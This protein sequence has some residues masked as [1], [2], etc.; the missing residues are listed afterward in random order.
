M[1]CLSTFEREG[2]LVDTAGT[3][4]HRTLRKEAQKAIEHHSKATTPY[5]PP[6]Q[7]I[8]LGTPQLRAW[9]YAHPFALLYYLSSISSAFAAL[10]SETVSRVSSPLKMVIYSDEIK[11]DNPLRPDNGR[12]TQSIYWCFTDWPQWALQRAAVWLLLGV[13]RTTLVDEMPGGESGL[14]RFVLNV[15]F[16][17]TSPSFTLGILMPVGVTALLV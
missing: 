16:R 4:S 5:G 1:A 17:V 3:E 7:T 11:P 12:G 9:E 15:C 10:M 13:I 2:L 14:M 6:V 8:D